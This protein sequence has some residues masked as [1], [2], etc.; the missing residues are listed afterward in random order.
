MARHFKDKI[1]EVIGKDLN[2]MV[3]SWNLCAERVFGYMAEEMIGPCSE[4]RLKASLR[5][6]GMVLRD[7]QFHERQQRL[8]IVR[9]E[10]GRTLIGR[11]G[12]VELS[13]RL[14]Q[15]SFCHEGDSTVFRRSAEAR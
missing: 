3:T 4:Q 10:S 13:L 2:G 8:R 14:T 7:L 9:V 1:I 5:A 6:I 15:P 11:A 12:F